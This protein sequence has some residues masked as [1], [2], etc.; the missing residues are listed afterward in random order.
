MLFEEISEYL[1]FSFVSTPKSTQIIEEPIAVDPK[2]K[3]APPPAGKS[4]STP[5]TDQTVE[6][7]VVYKIKALLLHS[8]SLSCDIT[9]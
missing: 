8:Q 3:K 2:A 7:P 5:E 6:I 9:R 1:S 4:K